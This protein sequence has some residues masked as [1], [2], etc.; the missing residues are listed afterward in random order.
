MILVT[1]TFNPVIR[2]GLAFNFSVFYYEIMS[3]PDKACQLAKQ[4]ELIID[5]I[6]EGDLGLL[7]DE[8][9]GPKSSL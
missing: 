3:S 7:A 4:V 5:G 6:M 8:M 2:L 9:F 1:M